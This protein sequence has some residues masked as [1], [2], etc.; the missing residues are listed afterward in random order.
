MEESSKVKILW[1][2]LAVESHREYSSSVS[3]GSK[4]ARPV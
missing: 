4:V 2:K 1:R 3:Y